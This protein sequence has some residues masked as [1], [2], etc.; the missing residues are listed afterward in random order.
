M[1]FLLRVALL[2]VIVWL[3][4]QLSSDVG[5]LC[6]IAQEYPDASAFFDDVKIEGMTLI[7]S[8]DYEA[9]FVLPLEQPA[10]GLVVCFLLM[11]LDFLA[12]TIKRRKEKAR[13]RLYVNVIRDTRRVEDIAAVTAL[14]YKLVQKDLRK[15]VKK[16]K[17]DFMGTYYNEAT[18]E[19]VF[20]RNAS[21]A[22]QNNAE[23]PTTAPVDK[24][25]NDE[26]TET[27]A[28][29]V[30]SSNDGSPRT[31]VCGACGANVTVVGNGAKCEYC[32]SRLD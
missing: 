17:G 13:R 26:A 3:C 27:N 9:V 25:Q 11:F 12:L 18:Q 8:Q 22:P 4:V 29:S 6:L 15:I 1:N 21:N 23:S 32:G 20:P 30:A 28:S 24:T 14:P 31:V 5:R 16:G 19:I 10:L 7:V 2:G